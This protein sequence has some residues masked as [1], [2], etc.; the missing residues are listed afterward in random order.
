MSDSRYIKATK[1]EQNRHGADAD[2]GVL[3]GVHI[4]ATLRMQL[5]R[6]CASATRP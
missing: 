6:S 1:Q 3:D 4:G 2:G 5:N